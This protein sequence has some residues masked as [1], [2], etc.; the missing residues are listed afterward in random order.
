[1]SEFT[2]L[3]ARD[4]HEFSAWLAAPAGKPR[5]AARPTAY[6]LAP[7]CVLARQREADG[8][9]PCRRRD[10]VCRGSARGQ[11]AFDDA[12]GP[13]EAERANRSLARPRS[14]GFDKGLCRVPAIDNFGEQRCVDG[15]PPFGTVAQDRHVGDFEKFARR[16]E[17][18]ERALYAN[19][20]SKN[21]ASN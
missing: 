15:G 7:C 8:A 13:A 10:K 2:T 9:L 20:D 12:T 21:H 1:M 17:K 3:M 11:N 16:R 14:N 5:G 18:R 19:I 4:G 6:C